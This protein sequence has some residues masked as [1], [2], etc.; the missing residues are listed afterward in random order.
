MRVSFIDRMKRKVQQG[1]SEAA[2]MAQ[3]TLETTKL[4]AMA[5]LKEKEIDHLF[6][7]IGQLTYLG[8]SEGDVSRSN[9]EAA[10]LCERIARLKEEVRAIEEQVKLVKQTASSKPSAGYASYEEKGADGGAI[11]EPDEIRVICSTC[12]TDNAMDAQVC[13]GCGRVFP[14]SRRRLR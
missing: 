13:R 11:G 5:V 7:K 4:R 14:G 9:A 6:R 1:A 8:Y 2:K 12:K 3:Q 10:E